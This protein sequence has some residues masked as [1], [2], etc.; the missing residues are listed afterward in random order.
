MKVASVRE[1]LRLQLII[2]EPFKNTA[3]PCNKML[4]RDCIVKAKQTERKQPSFTYVA[5]QFRSE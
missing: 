5:L 4:G 2:M 3:S 1:D